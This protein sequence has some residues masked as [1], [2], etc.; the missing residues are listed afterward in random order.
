MAGATAKVR[1]Y[2][3]CRPQERLPG[4]ELRSEMPTGLLHNWFSMQSYV[5]LLA[6][7][8]IP[9]AWRMGIMI[10]TGPISAFV[11]NWFWF[12]TGGTFLS[13]VPYL[14]GLVVHQIYDHI[15]DFRAIEKENRELKEKIGLITN[16]PHDLASQDYV[17]D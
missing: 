2:V 17:D 15:K 7:Y 3:V 9:K 14:V 10:F 6:S 13:F 11:G 5:I 16:P 1:K 4:H 8:F 12:F